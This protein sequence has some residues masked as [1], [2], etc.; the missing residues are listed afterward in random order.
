[1]LRRITFWHVIVSCDKLPQIGP[2]DEKLSIKNNCI[3]FLCNDL[4]ALIYNVFEV[5][6]LDVQRWKEVKNGDYRKNLNVRNA[7]IIIAWATML[8]SWLYSTVVSKRFCL[9][10]M[11]PCPVKTCSRLQY[12]LIIWGTPCQHSL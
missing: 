3:A 12:W 5:L 1:M 9:V 6:M 7:F 4:T 11:C 2:I 10:Y 8:C